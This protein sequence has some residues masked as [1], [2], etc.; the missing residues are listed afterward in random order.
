M[1]LL[2]GVLVIVTTNLQSRAHQELEGLKAINLTEARK[3]GR[4]SDALFILNSQMSIS[5]L[6]ASCT[7]RSISRSCNVNNI[8]SSG[9]NQM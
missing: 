7:S 2:L 1:V 8:H 6:G 4:S 3:H 5:V 9:L